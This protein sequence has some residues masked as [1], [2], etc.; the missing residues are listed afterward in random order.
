MLKNNK[1]QKKMLNGLA[2]PA[3]EEC[4]NINYI[5][6]NEYNNLQLLNLS[7]KNNNLQLLNLSDKIN[8]SQNT[9]K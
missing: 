6:N 9:K 2:S 5:I 8:N 1:K 3:F 4:Q 7:V